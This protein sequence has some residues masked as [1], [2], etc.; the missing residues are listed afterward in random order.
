MR[1]EGKVAKKRR[2]LNATTKVHPPS[3]A[4]LPVEQPNAKPFHL[5]F[6]FELH[7]SDKGEKKT[8]WFKDKIDMQKY[9]K[10]YEL[11]A[12]DYTVQQTPPKK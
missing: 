1:R 4:P 7:H 5:C 6:P 9:I 2:N 10:R 11:K 3:N 12:K 8:C